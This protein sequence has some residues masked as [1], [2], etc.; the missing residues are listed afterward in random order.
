MRIKEIVLFD[1]EHT[2]PAATRLYGEGFEMR[3]QTSCTLG[4][5]L[6]VGHYTDAKHYRLPQPADAQAVYGVLTLSP[7][8]GPHTLLAF[9]S[10]RRFSG[11][12]YVKPSDSSRHSGWRLS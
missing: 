5:L 4:A 12:F 3:S 8:E 7:P 1:V 9:T 6:D 10:C 2:L 11:Q